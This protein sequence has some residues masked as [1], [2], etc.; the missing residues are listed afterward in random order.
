[1]STPI[2]ASD[3]VGCRDTVDDGVSGFLCRPKDAVHLADRMLAFVGLAPEERLRMG[4]AGRA[5]MEREFDERIVLNSYAD[6]L[7]QWMPAR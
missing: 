1:M 4:R 6:L 3:S 2:I 5:K 7:T